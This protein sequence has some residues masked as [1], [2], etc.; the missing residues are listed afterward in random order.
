[1]S[2]QPSISADD[3]RVS[4]ARSPAFSGPSTAV[5]RST[6]Q[7]V[8]FIHRV[9]SRAIC[10]A[11][12]RAIASGRSAA[13]TSAGMPPLRSNTVASPSGSRSAGVSGFS[14]S[15]TGVPRPDTG[16]PTICD[17]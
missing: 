11:T 3:R 9:R 8:S 10:I 4:S 1:M 12:D 16:R 7:A 15:T 17:G 2:M 5:R 13:R 6:S 14:R